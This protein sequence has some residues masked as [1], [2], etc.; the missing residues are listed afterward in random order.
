MNNGT[1]RV[2]VAQIYRLLS[3]FLLI[4]I[5]VLLLEMAPSAPRG[6]DA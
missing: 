6:H 4:E 2:A 3:I 1:I 5:Q